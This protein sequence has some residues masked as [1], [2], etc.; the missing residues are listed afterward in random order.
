MYQMKATKRF[1]WGTVGAMAVLVSLVWV[2]FALAQDE[3]VDVETVAY[4]PQGT[5][6]IAWLLL[7]GV[8]VMFMQAGFAMLETGLTR[9]KNAVNIMTKNLM[10]FCI[11]SI[12][13]WAIGYSIMYG[14]TIG[15]L[16]GWSSDWFFSPILV[17]GGE[18]ASGAFAESGAWFFQM[19]FCATAATIVSGAMAERTKLVGYLFYSALISGLLYPITGHWIWGSGWLNSM[20]MRDFAGST[21]VHSVG[22]WAALAGAIM[23]GPRLGKYTKDGKANAIPGHNIVLAALGVF[24]LWFGWYGFN[25]GSTLAQVEGI[26]YVAVTTTLAAAA[27]AC[28]A[29][30]VSWFSYGKPDL[31]M[32]LN[33]VIAGL[34]G[35][36]A[37]CASVAPWAAVVI[38]GVA[39]VLVFYSV[40]FFDQVL[41][42][43]DPVGAVSVHG[44]CGAWGTLSIGLFGSRS[45][46]ILFWD[47]D[48]A[49]K[50][51]L[52]YG[53][54]FSQLAIQATG[55]I[56]V[57]GFTFVAALIMFAVIKA[58]V[59]LR[60]SDEEQLEG[61]DIGEHGATA[62]P[63][64]QTSAA[65]MGRIPGSSAA[66][67]HAYGLQPDYVPREVP[68]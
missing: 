36:T 28:A 16:F 43:D 31:T 59:G 63:D 40:L 7:T 18:S 61:L 54:G 46:D 12:L 32:A 39:G 42:I 49:I 10:D 33:G 9:A 68:T 62:Y 2:G 65:A 19:V 56:A 58:T 1:P 38:G 35:I 8:L 64:F 14:D 5:A 57:F 20:G 11:G 60:V 23:V 41:K 27:G 44:I 55:V 21:V 15:G 30:A 25:P 22:A 29:L 45:I 4:L 37:P 50:D 47:A 6:D 51:G 24:I 66:P 52:F 3:V 17:P 53:G 67:S 34:V 26:A 48:T 13:F